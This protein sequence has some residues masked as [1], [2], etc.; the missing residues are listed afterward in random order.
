MKKKAVTSF[1]RDFV[2][3]HWTGQLDYQDFRKADMVTEAVSEDLSVD[4]KC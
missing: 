1:E 4:A 2:F 3:S